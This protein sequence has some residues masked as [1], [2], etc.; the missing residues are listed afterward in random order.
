MGGSQYVVS[1][2]CLLSG[3]YKGNIT[4]LNLDG[5]QQSW[6]EDYTQA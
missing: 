2:F 4:P 5:F 1:A 3:F 6:Q